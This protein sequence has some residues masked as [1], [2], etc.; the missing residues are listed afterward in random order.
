MDF[1]LEVRKN[2]SP[3]C[4]SVKRHLMLPL[5]CFQTARCKGENAELEAYNRTCRRGFIYQPV[6]WMKMTEKKTKNEQRREHG[7]GLDWQSR[8]ARAEGVTRLLS[9]K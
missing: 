9:K 5:A 8:C 1:F 7:L 4:V 6:D 2:D 3:T